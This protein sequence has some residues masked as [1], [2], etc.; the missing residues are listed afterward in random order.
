MTH[1]IRLISLY[2]LPAVKAR[3][4][5]PKKK[6]KGRKPRPARKGVF[7]VS[8]S[9]FFADYVWRDGGEPTIPGTDVPKLRLIPLGPKARG[10]V[11]DDI[12]RVIEG[13]QRTAEGVTQDE[14]IA[15]LL[16]RYPQL[17]RE[18][19]PDGTEIIRRIGLKTPA[20]EAR[21]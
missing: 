10:A 15:E 20:E 4:A 13:L 6:I 1:I 21:T 5:N 11:S 2:N 7:D 8:K 16:R 19:L 18:V 12:N 3:K 9:K 14:F 17:R